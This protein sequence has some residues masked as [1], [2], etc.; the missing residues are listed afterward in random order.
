[1]ARASSSASSGQ[2]DLRQVWR[3]RWWIAVAV[4]VCAGVAYGL[5]RAQPSEYTAASLAQV[6]PAQQAEGRPLGSDELLQLTNVYAEQARSIPTVTRA[7]EEVRGGRSLDAFRDSVELNVDPAGGLVELK[8]TAGTAEL[9]RRSSS[10]YAAAFQT[11]VTNAQE[12]QQRAVIRRLSRAARVIRAR[13]ERGSDPTDEALRVQADALQARI[14][15]TLATPR[16]T[17]RVIQPA[18]LPTAPSSPRPV[19]NAAL[20]ALLAL[21][22]G[23]LLAYARI[24]LSRRFS[25]ADDA[26]AELGL[27]LLGRIPEGDAD[28][29]ALL[30][31]LRIVEVSI[32]VAL[33]TPVMAPN[34]ESPGPP[35]GRVL[36]FTSS[37]EHEGKTFVASHL[38]K[39]LAAHGWR[40]LLIDADL[41]RP[42]VHLVHSRPLSPGL[43]DMLESHDARPDVLAGAPAENRGNGSLNILSA[44]AGSPAAISAL[45]SGRMATVLDQARQVADFVILDAPPVLP[46]ADP[47]A[48]AR[49]SDAVVFV[50][51][52]QRTK[53]RSAERA[54]EMLQ[55]TRAPILGVVANR[56]S[57]PV[58]TYGSYGHDTP[59]APSGAPLGSG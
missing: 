6:V 49:F 47:A 52:V 32:E 44:G 12:A 18:A 36:L 42:S 7:W 50:L 2:R 34:A 37:G 15:E 33:E 43:A 24:L 46:V 59:P 19:L 55:T 53:R 51:D 4:V 57:D 8:A 38:S 9:A 31:A 28:S 27:R 10:A 29:R 56:T 26:G 48:L 30:E 11:N 58:Q 25:D 17:V 3:Y 45:A 40:V 39:S 35:L 1:M 23:C 54:I 16:D 14:S 5:S 22:L 21:V 13:L 41:R 20:A